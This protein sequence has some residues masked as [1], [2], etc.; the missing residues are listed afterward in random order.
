[1][2]PQPALGVRN[3]FGEAQIF[4][5]GDT[6]LLLRLVSRLCRLHPRFAGWRIELTRALNELFVSD[7]TV[8]ISL[9]EPPD[10]PEMTWSFGANIRG[11]ERT[12]EVTRDMGIQSL[13]DTINKTRP[14]KFFFGPQQTTTVFLDRAPGHLQ[15]SE[16]AN[17]GKGIQEGPVAQGLMSLLRDNDRDRIHV[18]IV[19]RSRNRSP[20]PLSPER[21]SFL[22]R[23][24]LLLDVLHRGIEPLY[25][26]D[27]EPNLDS[28]IN[29][30]PPR[31]RQTLD[32]LFSDRTERQIALD[33]SLSVHTVHDYV[34]ALYRRFGVSSRREL[35]STGI[36]QSN[37]AQSHGPAGA[38]EA[39]VG[40]NVELGNV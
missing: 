31:L 17:L 25:R 16:L 35:I 36:Q 29:R 37:P 6:L 39:F 40:S 4:S 13:V 23:E 3:M 20:Q 12:A 33:M 27:R 32:Y 34:K 21:P 19:W 10:N 28:R 5:P 2:Y 14:M 30:L 18:I 1:M 11:E 26:A 7:A 24:R 8:L 9:R 38:T 15:S 22:L